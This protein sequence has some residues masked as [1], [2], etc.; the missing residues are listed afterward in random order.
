M[1]IPVFMARKLTFPES[2]SSSS[3]RRLRDCVINGAA[4]HP[5]A[6]IVE[7]ETTGIQLSLR[8]MTAE[9]R[10]GIAN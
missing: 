6:N 7:D 5:G 8:D 9:E 1:G 2:V 4:I 10:E 3:Y